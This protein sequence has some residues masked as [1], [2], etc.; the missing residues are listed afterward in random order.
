MCMTVCHVREQPLPLYGLWLSS[1][2]H[3]SG[4]DLSRSDLSP[5]PV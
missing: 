1:F 5:N 2:W 3:P 4:G